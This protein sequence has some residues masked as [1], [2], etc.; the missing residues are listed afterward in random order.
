LAALKTDEPITGNI[1]GSVMPYLRVANM[2]TM[3]TIVLHVRL[4]IKNF[5]SV[6]QTYSYDP[7]GWHGVT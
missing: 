2:V 4:A 7:G 1:T 3:V 5:I 6:E